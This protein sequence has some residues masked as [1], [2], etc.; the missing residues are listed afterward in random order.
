MIDLNSSD[1]CSGP[2]GSMT[3][4]T[5]RKKNP[6]TLFP[7]PYETQTK[8]PRPRSCHLPCLPWTQPSSVIDAFK[9]KTTGVGG[10]GE[11]QKSQRG[12]PQQLDCWLLQVRLY[13]FYSTGEMR[14]W[15][16]EAHFWLPGQEPWATFF[17]SSFV[18]CHGL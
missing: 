17:C 8:C 9:L 2:Q 13:F 4:E 1:E 11:E 3:T 16:P 18:V 14:A 12:S 7:D 10:W 6:P 15:H 5:R